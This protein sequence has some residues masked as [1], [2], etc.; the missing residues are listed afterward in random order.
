MTAHVDHLPPLL[1]GRLDAPALARVMRAAALAEELHAGQRRPDGQPYITHVVEVARLVLSWCP[2]ADADALTTALLHDAVEDQAARLAERG[3]HDAPTEREQA[4][5]VVSSTFG[6]TVARRLE[7]LTNH[8]FE[9]IAHE[10]FGPLAAAEL[11]ECK[12]RLYAEHVAHAVHADSWVAAIKLADFS[13]NAWRLDRRE[14]PGAPREAAREVPPG[15]AAVPRA[16]REPWR[17][18]HPLFAARESLRAQLE[19]VWAR[20]YAG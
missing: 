19:E 20:D 18:G 13:T 16:A 1:E 15:D 4:L 12:A 11:T 2:D 6:V 17:R 7:L 3:P 10:R 9:A 8:D 14:R 5:A